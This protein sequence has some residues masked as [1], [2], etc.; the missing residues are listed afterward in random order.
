MITHGVRLTYFAMA[1]ARRGEPSAR[2]GFRQTAGGQIATTRCRSSGGVIAGV[3]RRDWFANLVVRHMMGA[4]M[5]LSV[6]DA[7]E[8]LTVIWNAADRRA[9]A[10]PANGPVSDGANGVTG[11]A[12]GAK[13]AAM[14][15]PW[16][17]A[18]AHPRIHPTAGDTPGGGLW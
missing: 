3:R 17:T 11:R 15:S 2:R 1:T 18:Q 6:V 13:G 4:Q 10:G 7:T 12:R 14:R 16:S 5:W 8:Q 9:L